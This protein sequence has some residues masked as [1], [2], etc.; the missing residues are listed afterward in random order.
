MMTC[1]MG[2][3]AVTAL[4]VG[5]APGLVRAAEPTRAGEVAGVLAALPPAAG[6]NAASTPATSPARVGSAARTS[7]GASPTA[8]A[9]TAPVPMPQVIISQVRTLDGSVVTVA[10]FGGPV[11]YVLH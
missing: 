8:S 4:A 6:G 11:Q 10:T 9:V 3:G 7:P 5:E 2:T 1:G